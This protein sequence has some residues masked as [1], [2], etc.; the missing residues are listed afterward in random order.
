MKQFLTY[1]RIIAGIC[2]FSILLQMLSLTGCSMM[3]ADAEPVRTTSE[4]TDD[5]GDSIAMDHSDSVTSYFVIDTER[6][7]SIEL[8][9]YHPQIDISYSK[10]YA[11]IPYSPAV[12]SVAATRLCINNSDNTVVHSENPFEKIYPAS[13]TK[14]MTA[15][16]V[17]EQGNLDDIFTLE[18]PIDLGD[19]LA[20]SLDLA[21]GD[22]ISVRELLNGLLLESANDYAVALGRYVAGSEDR[23]VKMMNERA[24]ELGA[25]H[26][27]FVNP[28]G[29]HDENHYTTGYDLYLI[30]RELIT[31]DAYR[32]IA[33]QA[34]H[35]LTLTHQ[36]GSVV[37]K[38]LVNS[39]QYLTGAVSAPDGITVLCGKT[40]TTNEA[41][42]CLILLAVDETG[43]EYI[44][45]VC[46][47]STHAY[48]YTIMSEELSGI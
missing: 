22:Q 19:P 1:N 25:T 29:L 12:D 35:D 40:G 17:L 15:L 9:E 11:V 41:G 34:A 45:V 14:I 4:N 20:V 7:Y 13:V 24:G 38:S 37:H 30:Y 36:D 5:N 48:L 43:A 47:I 27:H 28:H 16:L 46:G 18:A 10:N 2:I 26:T 8:P 33:G 39:N 42:C 21:V 31:H 44:T 32:E 3:T 23:F 6:P